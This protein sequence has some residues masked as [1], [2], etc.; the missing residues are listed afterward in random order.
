MLAL[1]MEEAKVVSRSGG[2]TAVQQAPRFHNKAQSGLKCLIHL[3]HPPGLHVQSAQRQRAVAGEY[4]EA[5]SQV[6]V[7][8][9]VENTRRC[10]LA[11]SR[12]ECDLAIVGGEVPCDL[13]HLLQVRLLIMACAGQLTCGNCMQALPCWQQHHLGCELASSAHVLPWSTGRSPTLDCSDTLTSSPLAGIHHPLLCMH[14]SQD[15]PLC[16][17]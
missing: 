8:L 2:G 9:Q 15:Q 4:K 12:G 16:A 5:H 13:E 1:A 11:V 17:S 7:N 14:A 6:A 10:C 3:K